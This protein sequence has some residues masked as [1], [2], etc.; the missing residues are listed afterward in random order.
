M[1][2]DIDISD[3]SILYMSV[4]KM[5]LTTQI[6]G[7]EVLDIKEVS[8]IT[9]LNLNKIYELLRYDLFPKPLRLKNK[10]FWKLSEI[11]AYKESKRKSAE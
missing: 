11:E 2:I 4:V 10:N 8:E 5:K 3:I 1:L 9:G 7:E 6:D